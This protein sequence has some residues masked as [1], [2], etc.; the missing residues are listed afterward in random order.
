[1]LRLDTL[2]LNNVLSVDLFAVIHAHISMLCAIMPL[3]VGAHGSAM[4]PPRR[5]SPCKAQRDGGTKRRS[6]SRVDRRD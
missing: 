2:N 4:A 6:D 3:L 1:M 5:D